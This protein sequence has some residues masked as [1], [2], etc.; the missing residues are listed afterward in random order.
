MSTQP[1]SQGEVELAL[2]NLPGWHFEDNKLS[3]EF[4]FPNHLFAVAVVSAI[5]LFQEELN[6]H[7]TLSLTYNKLI[8]VTTTHDAGNKVTKKDI[9][10][11]HKIT[12][13]V[14]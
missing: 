12:E 9:T 2:S 14:E 1:L 10:L 4:E 3:A 5:G 13:F 8:V 11:A 7:A 6:H